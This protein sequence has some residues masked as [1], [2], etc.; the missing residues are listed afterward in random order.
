MQ[1][2]YKGLVT[3]KDAEGNEGA[4]LIPGLAEEIPDPIPT[5]E[6]PTSSSSARASSTPT[7]VRSRRATSRTRSSGCSSWG[8]RRVHGRYRWRHEVPGGRKEEDGDIP[9]I[10]AND[11]TGE[12][13]AD[14]GGADS[15][16]L[17]ARAGELG[18]HGR[19]KSPFKNSNTIPGAGPYKIQIVNPTREIILT[20]NRNFNVPGIAK[21]K[22]D[23]MTRREVVGHEDDAGRHQRTARLHDGGSA[24]ATSWRRSRP[25]TRTGSDSIRT[26]RTR[27]G[28]S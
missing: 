7:A 23:K 28:S 16:P 11:S 26:R 17:R 3:Y 27:T 10:E 20:K 22:I 25:S 13:T 19:A 24:P 1:L 4:Q 8:A 21:G 6:R 14:P 15:I 18:A 12:I 5:A 9:G 2:V